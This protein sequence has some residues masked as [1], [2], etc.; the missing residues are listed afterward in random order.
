MPKGIYLRGVIIREPHSEAT[1]L[2]IGLAHLGKTFSDAQKKRMSE[3]KMGAKYPNRKH[4]AKGIT[5]ID[6]VCLFCKSPFQTDCFMP[7]KKYCNQT[8]VHKALPHNHTLGMK[9][10]EKQKQVMRDRKGELHHNWKGGF[11]KVGHTCRTMPEYLKWRSDCFQ[12][13]NFTCQ[14]CK[15][16]GY[17][18][19]HHIKSFARIIK[20]NNINTREDARNCLELWE[21]HNGKTLCEMCHS[22]TDNY[23]GRARRLTA[24]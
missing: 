9:G 20:E 3:A 24:I 17:V 2:K 12:R 23:K 7:N 10:S 6:K 14:D 4:Y 21:L 8:C 11:T 16:V 13:D 19:V 18:T 5:E 15:S 1:K 22:L